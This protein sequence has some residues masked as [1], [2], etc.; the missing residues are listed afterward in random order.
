MRAKVFQTQGFAMK[1]RIVE[2]LG[3]SA[4][5]L[6]ALVREGLAANDRS[7]VRMAALQAAIQHAHD[8]ATAPADLSA[9]CR[10]AGLD[11]SSIASLIGNARLSAAGTVMVAGLA[12]LT[13]SL[14]DDVRAMIRAVEAKDASASKIATDR[15][16]AIREEFPVTN[17]LGARQITRMI[18]VPSGDADS[19]HRLIMDLHK[20]LNH[21]A[22]SCAEDVVAGAHVH[23]LGP[24]DRPL[25]QAFMR[26]VDSTRTLKFNHPGL[27]TTAARSGPRL[28]IQNDIGET[29]A[30]VLVI[31]IEDLVVTITLTDVHRAR[32]EFFCGLLDH[33]AV[34]WSGLDRDRAKDP[35]DLGDFFLVTGRYEAETVAQQLTFLETVGGMIV[36]LIDWN[37]ARK[38]L[39]SLVA[40]SDAVKILDWAARHR[41]GHR[42]F[43]ELGGSDLVGT[44]VRRA[45]AARIGFNEQLGAVLGREGAV[46]FLKAVLRL[47]TEGRLHGTN[48]RL[49]RD[50]IEAELVRHL[51]RTDDALLSIVIRQAG[52]AQQ[53][54]ALIA[55]HLADR[56]LGR[57]NK[58]AALVA[59]AKRIEEKA[60]Q[61][62]VEAR[63][64]ITRLGGSTTVGQ[65]V[66]AAERAIDELE[67]AAF[68]ASLMPGEVTSRALAPLAELCTTAIA[69]A[70][71][72]ASGLDAATVVPE[73]NRIDA[74]DAFASTT[75]LVQLEQAADVAERTVTSLVFCGD[76]DWKS[77]LSVLELGRALERATDQMAAIG[78]LMH[79]HVMADLSA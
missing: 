6:P 52:L 65:L 61:I 20:I 24:D 13:S 11:L 3:Q 78:H 1:A 35:G 68:V 75:R 71:T 17:E 39:R 4:I 44:A 29:D 57:A 45:S 2:H 32:T 73:G 16:A 28:I 48:A 37:K 18:G 70:E 58:S 72:A 76:L 56:Q 66:T 64:E 62:A 30:H 50:A 7:K 59:A 12:E 53:I 69:C 27:D 15:L 60:D 51:Q 14:E 19:L 10:S 43:L 9:E 77:A 63:K 23:S 8:P 46:D 5:I 38:S 26:G 67:Q 31:S 33:F 25:I 22:A 40:N 42:A 55:H 47:C 21:L 49:V 74:E 54:A 79:T 41:V 36:F 34:H